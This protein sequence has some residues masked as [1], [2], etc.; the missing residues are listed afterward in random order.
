MPQPFHSAHLKIE[1][2]EKHIGD[3]LMEI[4]AFLHRDPYKAI[5]EHKGQPGAGWLEWRVAVSEQPPV[6]IG[7]FAGDAIHC[8]RS[9]LDHIV[10]ELV[11]RNRTTLTKQEA[12]KLGFPIYDSPQRFESEYPRKVKGASQA[13]VDLICAA[14]PY[15][16][17][18]EPLW[19]LHELD[20]I[21]KHRVLLTVGSA[22]SIEG[23]HV[24]L[25]HPAFKPYT[26]GPFNSGAWK[27][28]YPLIDG[29]KLCAMG[30]AMTPDGA[31]MYMNA[32]FAFDVAFGEPGLV[33]GEPI[34]PTLHQL[35]QVTKGLVRTFRAI[36]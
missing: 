34:L 8:L 32:E 17:G 29:A 1:R 3:L 12:R 20:V 5:R 18:N 33:E 21:D 6:E 30:P 15:K 13:A 27:P 36:V 28:I 22:A 25:D 35:V 2:A 19:W 7:L 4:G 11:E 31:K 23:I 14:K 26:V 9:A 24:A 16:G 10:W